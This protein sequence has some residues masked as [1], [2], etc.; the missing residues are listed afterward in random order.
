ML[1][2][3]E[4][5]L[6]TLASLAATRLL[7]A[8][9][10]PLPSDLVLNR[11]TFGA[12]P[13]ARAEFAA[14]G[15][16]AWLEQQLALPAQDAGL[17]ARLSAQ[18]LRLQYEAGTDPTEEP[19]PARDEILPLSSLNADPAT[20]LPLFDWENKIAWPERVRPA[21][22]VIAASL[23]RALHAPAQLREVMTQFWHDHFNVHSQKS[24]F[25]PAFFP[26][27][28]AGLRDRAFGNFRD[29]LGFTATS[30]AM[31]FYLNNDESRASPANENYARELLEL[32]TLGAGNYL[33][34]SAR[35]WS[36]VPLDGNGLATG[37]I[38]EDVFEVARA[39]TGWT[40][41]DGR[42]ILDEQTAPK[43]GTFFYVE[44]WHDPYQKRILAREFAPNRPA[45]ADGND[46]L[47]ML[48][49]H[50]G[51]ARFVCE[52]LARRLLS[53]SPDAGL[54]DRMAQ[55]F[56]AQAA[57]PDQMAQVLRVL[58]LD[59]AFVAT[60][61]SKFRRP[62]EFL[63]AALRASG[64]QTAPEENGFAWQLAR[65]GWQ[66]HSFAPPT[67]HPDV[68]AA[69]E[70]GTVLLR[71]VDYVI[72]L[73][74]PWFVGI[75]DRLSAQIPEATKTVA[76]LLAFWE[77]RLLGRPIGAVAALASLDVA[78]DEPLPEAES[79]RHDWAS[80]ALALAALSPEFIFR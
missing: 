4:F 62:N 22:E 48:A 63:L 38:D 15:L 43:S 31:L 35:H 2:R 34:R 30:P 71:Y 5:F 54:I 50:P 10:P 67:G 52:K 7:A 33:S 68:S 11:L 6:S 13:A 37:Y 55:T 36:D 58:V 21:D 60:P 80:M 65:A 32:H 79:D 40:V 44:A 76:E 59:P 70:T 57:A 14:L 73:H 46:V 29:L 9:S 42:W 64:A 41:G 27:Y 17:S 53:D 23:T 20:L 69:W 72:Y 26:T 49:N 12:T 75:S 77:D 1:N 47:D 74:E 18:R 39:F 56:L 28:D 19:W 66:Q 78:P 3:R 25:I 24:E 16:P 51:T 8:A 61:P 45:M